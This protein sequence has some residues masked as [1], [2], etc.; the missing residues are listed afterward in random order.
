MASARQF[1]TSTTQVLKYMTLILRAWDTIG[2]E[3]VVLPLVGESAAIISAVRS[4]IIGKP[5]PVL[6]SQVSE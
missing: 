2:Y 6:L 4:S 1:L 3:I 5:G